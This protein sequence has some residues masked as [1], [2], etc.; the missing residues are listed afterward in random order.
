MGALAD[1]RWSLAGAG[2]RALR[3][4]AGPLITLGAMVYAGAAI[5]ATSVAAALLLLADD[6]SAGV[7]RM[8]SSRTAPDAP[9]YDGFG[10]TFA[11]W[12]GVAWAAALTL[13]VAFG[14]VGAFQRHNALRRI[15]LAALLASAALW[16]GNSVYM[17]AAT[18]FSIFGVLT[19]AHLAGL[20]VT[21]ALALRQWHLRK[22]PPG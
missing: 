10:L 8:Y 4:I 11:G 5:L 2:R 6:T 13:I 21:A 16:L 1:D 9:F 18:G 12:W 14:A 7:A 22:S 20:A 17:A 19:G 3:R 15:A